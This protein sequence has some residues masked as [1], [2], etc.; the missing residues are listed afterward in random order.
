M[1]ELAK[2][3]IVLALATAAAVWLMS[4]ALH[5]WPNTD[6]LAYGNPLPYLKVE[7]DRPVNAVKFWVE[8][9]GGLPY[10][11][12]WLYVNGR[13]AASGDPGTDAAAKCGDEVAAVV[14]YH[15]GTKKLEGRIL[16]TKPIKAPGGGE[17]KRAIRLIQTAQA[18][19]A[20]TGDMDQT[21]P[22]LRFD[23]FCNIDYICDANDVCT[24]G[25]LA[26][27]TITT[28]TPNAV[29][30]VGTV[31]NVTYT[32]SWRFYYYGS[33][34]VSQTVP[35]YVFNVPNAPASQLL[36]GGRA[37]AKI[38]VNY[39]VYSSWWSNT[40]ILD[41]YVNG[42]Q[43]AHC[44]RKEVLTEVQSS[45]TEYV[46]PSATADYLFRFVGQQPDGTPVV[47]DANIKLYERNDGSFGA[48][49]IVNPV[50]NPTPADL[51]VASPH[52]TFP[53]TT[54]SGTTY[55]GAVSLPFLLEEMPTISLHN[56][57]VSV[58]MGVFYKFLDWLRNNPQAYSL[59]GQ[60]LDKVTDTE[61][62]VPYTPVSRTGEFLVY[63]TLLNWGYGVST[64]LSFKTLSI[65]SLGAV[66]A[67]AVLPIDVRLPPPVLPQ[68]VTRT[69][70]FSY[71]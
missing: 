39:T 66:Y 25:S 61:F 50:D 68:N 11:R 55:L 58:Q 57:V 14:K 13:L 64:T 18:Y 38:D 26:S 47:I 10:E 60:A 32:L 31:C 22:P 19:R 9:F 40:Y 41:V 71:R 45:W 48:R 7:F 67:N 4:M 12:V 33:E 44:Q 56:D 53:I 69:Y 43:V 59:F 52:K 46:E 27:V 37:V 2:A 29:F 17:A 5:L 35:I 6:Q 42:T 63:Q 65:S 36:G 8:D 23:G 16:C 49:I 1:H 20:M 34:T 15:S 3:V 24:F 21:G 62:G 30:C 54:P 51:N 70:I 28:L